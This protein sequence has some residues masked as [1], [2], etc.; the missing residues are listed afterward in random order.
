MKLIF[1]DFSVCIFAKFVEWSVIQR[2]MGY[3]R[4]FACNLFSSQILL[5]R[6]A[7]IV[8]KKQKWE[9]KDV[10]KTGY[11]INIRQMENKMFYYHT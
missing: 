1:L 7:K 11:E 10:K 3:D 8:K 6:W 9:R 2:M 4:K 5:F